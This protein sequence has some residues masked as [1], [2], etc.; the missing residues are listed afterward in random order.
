[1]TLLEDAK[2]QNRRKAVKHTITDEHIELA[3]AWAN[4]E[5]TLTAVTRSLKISK[6]AHYVT[7][8]VLA[9]ALKEYILRQSV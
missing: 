5:I 3:L 6:D 8:G 2:A 9:R 7:Y 4:E 1:M